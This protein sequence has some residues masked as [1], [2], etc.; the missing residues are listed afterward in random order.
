MATVQKFAALPIEKYVDI[1]EKLKQLKSSA[2]I[3]STSSDTTNPPV[4]YQSG[5]GEDA[6]ELIDQSRHQSPERGVGGESKQ[7]F[8]PSV[9]P[10]G[11]PSDDEVV[12]GAIDA[13]ASDNWLEVWQPLM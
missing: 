6:N 10:P 12:N 13:T 7:T 5:G 3:P 8:K 1:L 2:N 11:L 9:P 4:T